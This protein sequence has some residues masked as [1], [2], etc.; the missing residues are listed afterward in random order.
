MKKKRKLLTSLCLAFST[1][2][3]PI[4]PERPLTY[5]CAKPFMH[6]GEHASS[7]DPNEISYHWSE[8]TPVHVEREACAQ[9]ADAYRSTPAGK[10][11]GMLIRSRRP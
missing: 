2:E 6:D 8:E 1:V 10:S 5:R 3:N 9:I 7:L 11:I 4:H